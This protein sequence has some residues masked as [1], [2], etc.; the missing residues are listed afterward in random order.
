MSVRQPRYTKEEHA[1]LGS[2]M[3]DSR[4]RPQVE[5]G[6][7]GK[8]VAIDIE[9][10]EYEVADQTVEAA[11]RLLARCPDA[12]IWAVRIGYPAVHRFGTGSRET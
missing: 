3:Y 1:R 10:G 11:Q 5:A 9:T 2:E 6:N 7:H 8:I 4:V 12:Q